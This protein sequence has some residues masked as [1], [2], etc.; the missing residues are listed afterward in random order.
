MLCWSKMEASDW[1]KFVCYNNL[2]Y[3]ELKEN[4]SVKI[5]CPILLSLPARELISLYFSVPL[6]RT[7]TPA[8]ATNIFMSSQKF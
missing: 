2:I 3:T 4:I 7:Q 6:G 8:A 5:S 1:L